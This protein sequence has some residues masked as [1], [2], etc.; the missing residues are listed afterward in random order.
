MKKCHKILYWRPFTLILS[1]RELD[2]W[3][4]LDTII[5]MAK[6]GV[7]PSN[8]LNIKFWVKREKAIVQNGNSTNS[9]ELPRCGPFRLKMRDLVTDLKIWVKTEQV[10]LRKLCLDFE[11]FFLGSS[12]YWV[13]WVTIVPV[14]CNIHHSKGTTSLSRHISIIFHSLAAWLG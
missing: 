11:L 14:A 2:S 7:K 5:Y 1:A 6:L 3:L 4:E 9:I 13:V 10:L 8:V 12:V